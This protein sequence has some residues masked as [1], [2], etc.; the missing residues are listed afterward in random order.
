MYR[1]CIYFDIIIGFLSTEDDVIPGNYGMK[2]QVAA[3]RWVQKTLLNLA[4]IPDKLRFF[5]EV[6]V[7]LVPVIT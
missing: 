6:P 4:V 3:L 2:D 1:A 5:A 7:E